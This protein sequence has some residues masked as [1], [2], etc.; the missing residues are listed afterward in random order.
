[1]WGGGAHG[2]EKTSPDSTG[3]R[4]R[5]ASA[6]RVS[7]CRRR[8]RPW[9]LGRCAH[10]TH[11]QS[12]GGPG[13]SRG[14]GGSR[15][16]RLRGCDGWSAGLAVALRSAIHAR[17]HHRRRG[18]PHPRWRR[19]R[20]HAARRRRHGCDERLRPRTVRVTATTVVWAAAGEDTT[21]RTVAISRKASASRCGSPARSPS[22]IRSRPRRAT[23]RSSRRWSDG[24]VTPAAAPGAHALT[25]PAVR[26][27][28]WSRAPRADTASG[29][30]VLA[31][32]VMGSACA[33]AQAAA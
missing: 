1:M 12:A 5:R 17:R 6:P 28:R 13:R 26:P 22:R 16:R 18:Y 15:R 19:G 14:A 31:R 21:A 10:E 20:R 27:A 4:E 30:A 32:G 3:G 23:S 29:A 33:G 9:R 7:A 2:G 24:S 8:R 11:E 25:V